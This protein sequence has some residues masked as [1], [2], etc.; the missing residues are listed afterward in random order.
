[1][2][3]T[4]VM[5]FAASMRL[6]RGLH[7]LASSA[8]SPPVATRTWPCSPVACGYALWS[9]SSSSVVALLGGLMVKLPG[10]N[11]A[12][13]NGMQ[14]AAT[15]HAEAAGIGLGEFAGLFNNFRALNQALVPFICGRIY[16]SL[17][18][19]GRS[20]G[21]AWLVLVVLVALG[22]LL[23]EQ[24]IHCSVPQSQWRPS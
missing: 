15:E 12:S 11:A 5:T 19:A 16:A 14:A 18:G 20:G 8:D 10:F 1:M 13:K 17:V 2:T 4:A 9:S 22:S 7:P 3:S 23:P 24:L 21:R 6:D